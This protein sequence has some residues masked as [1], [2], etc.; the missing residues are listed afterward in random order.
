MGINT[1]LFSTLS[2]GTV[3]N[4]YSFIHRT[5]QYMATRRALQRRYE[6][7]EFR[8]PVSWPRFVQLFASKLHFCRLYTRSFMSA[9]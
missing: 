3:G 1:L 2:S 6:I 7:D 8:V 9:D 5:V 4:I